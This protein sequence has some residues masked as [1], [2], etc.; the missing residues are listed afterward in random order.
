[1]RVCHVLLLLLMT[2]FF[3]SYGFDE[4]TWQSIESLE[5]TNPDICVE[6]FHKA[7][8]KENYDLQ[9]GDEEVVLLREAA[10]AGWTLE[11]TFE[12]PEK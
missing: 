8:A 10:E 6:G 12:P 3:L 4:A 7:A 5:M 11:R 1:M 2:V 9:N